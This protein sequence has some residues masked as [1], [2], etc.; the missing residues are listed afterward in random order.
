[1]PNWTHDSKYKSYFQKWLIDFWVVGQLVIIEPQTLQV[2]VNVL[3]YSLK[4][5]DKTL[6]LKTL[7]T[8]HITWI[9]QPGT[10]L[11]ALFLLAIF[12][13]S[14]RFYA[15]YQRKKVIINVTQLWTQPATLTTGLTR[16]TYPLLHNHFWSNQLIAFCLNLSPTLCNGIQ[17]YSTK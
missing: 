13:D 11:E 16:Y 7:H 12:Y 1:M 6:L 2:I 4:L 5:D 9:N 8:I 10:D 3:N 14:G 15:L 17:S